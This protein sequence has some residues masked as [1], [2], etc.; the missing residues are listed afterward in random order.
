MEEPCDEGGTEEEE[1]IEQEAHRDV[2]PEDG[3]V[4]VMGGIALVGKCRNKTAVLQGVGNERE[5]SEHTY[6]AIVFLIEFPCQYNAEHC[7]QHLH[8]SCIECSP[9]EALRRFL[10]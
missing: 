7:V 1:D 2:E 6:H 8:G 10:F 9:E 5:D 4:V 3:V